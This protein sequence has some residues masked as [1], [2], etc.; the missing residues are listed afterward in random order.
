MSRIYQSLNVKYVFDTEVGKSLRYFSLKEEE[1]LNFI[2]EEVQRRCRGAGEVPTEI[3]TQPIHPTYSS[4]AGRSVYMTVAI[5]FESCDAAKL[6]QD[7]SVQKIFL[8]D[9]GQSQVEPGHMLMLIWIL[10]M[11]LSR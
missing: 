9:I 10:M 5:V 2:A 7:F 1:N 3:S 4:G 6:V 8:L 11:M